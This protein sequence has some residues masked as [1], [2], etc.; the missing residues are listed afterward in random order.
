[1]FVITSKGL[2]KRRHHVI[3]VVM[4]SK[5]RQIFVMKSKIRHDV[6]KFGMKLKTRHDVKQF[7]MTLKSQQKFIIISKT[8]NDVTNLVTLALDLFL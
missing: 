3:F 8:R 1:M 7:I 6:K 5:I 2:S 4:S